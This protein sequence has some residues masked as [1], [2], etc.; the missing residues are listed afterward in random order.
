MDLRLASIDQLIE[1]LTSRCSSIS[2]AIQYR[3]EG[4]TGEED[5][6][7]HSF[8]NGDFVHCSGLVSLLVTRVEGWKERELFGPEDDEGNEL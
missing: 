4:F 8:M 2:L 3:D 7:T 1:E 6:V 5:Y